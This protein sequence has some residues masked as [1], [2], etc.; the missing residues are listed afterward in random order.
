MDK[1]SI[2]RYFL[3]FDTLKRGP[4]VMKLLPTIPPNY[5]NPNIFNTQKLSPTI[6][7]DVLDII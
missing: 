2:F 5:F 1:G 4:T 7:P 6:P 3:S